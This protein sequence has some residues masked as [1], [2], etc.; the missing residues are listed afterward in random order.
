MYDLCLLSTNLLLYK[1]S[2]EVRSLWWMI[3]FYNIKEIV[4]LQCPKNISQ[5]LYVHWNT[6]RVPMLLFT[7]FKEKTY[8]VNS[9]SSIEK[10]YVILHFFTW[11]LSGCCQTEQKLHLISLMAQQLQVLQ[12][13][14]H[15]TVVIHNSNQLKQIIHH[16][17]Y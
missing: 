17:N 4:G 7:W 11:K 12:V 2:H 15:Q 14:L 16:T 3:N 8:N 1:I 13:K 10:S 6:N 9:L 5:R